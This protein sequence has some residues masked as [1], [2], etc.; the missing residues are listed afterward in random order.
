MT[1]KVNLWHPCCYI[2]NN[3]KTFHL[4]Y[5]ELVRVHVIYRHPYQQSYLPLYI[6][7]RWGRVNEGINSTRSHF[8]YATSRCLLLR[9]IRKYQETTQNWHKIDKR[10]SLKYRPSSSKP[11]YNN[12]TKD[13]EGI[14]HLSTTN[15]EHFP[16][17]E[18]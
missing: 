8:G 17:F 16:R 11:L 1:L 18:C 14:F 4:Q 10:M 3:N 13:Y 6:Y 2:S 9:K 15:K 7:I 12:Y 5:V